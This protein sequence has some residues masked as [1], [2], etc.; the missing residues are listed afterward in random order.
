MREKYR[1]CLRWPDYYIE[2]KTLFLWFPYLEYSASYDMWFWNTYTTFNEAE[3]A[4]RAIKDFRNESVSVIQEYD[5]K[6]NK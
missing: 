6:F 5:F 1:I 4:M 3:E 2:K